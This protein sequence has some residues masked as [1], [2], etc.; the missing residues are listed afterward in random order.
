MRGPAV[1]DMLPLCSSAN[2]RDIAVEARDTSMPS[3]NDTK[4]CTSAGCRGTMRYYEK[5]LPERYGRGEPTPQHHDGKLMMLPERR[6]GWVCDL[7]PLHT[8][9]D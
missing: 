1:H 3:N 5:G 2:Q 9:L 6:P 8:D 4:P 7:D